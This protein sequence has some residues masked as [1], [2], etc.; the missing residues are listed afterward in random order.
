MYIRYKEIQKFKFSGIYS[1]TNIINGKSYIG[2]SKNIR[3]RIR[4]HLKLLEERKHI[5]KKLSNAVNKYGIDNFK[6]SVLS[7]CPQEYCIKLEQW[8]LDNVKPEYNICKIAG[9]TLG[10]KMKEST[11]KI[12]LKARLGS[13]HSEESRKKMSESR[14]GIINSK[15]SIEKGIITKKKK[16]NGD[17]VS[18]EVRKQMTE[19]SSLSLKGKSFEEKYGKEKS[20][21]I[22]Q[23]MS[24]AKK[25][26]KRNTEDLTNF[27]EARKLR[28]ESTIGKT[29]EEIY[30]SDK[31][32]EIKDKISKSNVSTENKK[33]AG[34]KRR[35]LPQSSDWITKRTSKRKIPLQVTELLT[36]KIHIFDSILETVKY[37]NIS[38]P[39]IINVLKKDGVMKY[40]KLKIEK[41]KF[42]S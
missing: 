18:K 13:K 36:G 28:I 14:K 38:E 19:N 42:L 2:S 34:L 6:F 30:G 12:L 27:L 21:T 17:I 4:T 31:A 9:A 20:N 39:S 1:I 3:D 8:F 11:K 25:E 40:K 16:Y 26:N 7:K 15:E 33:L 29:F 37:F 5:N 23:K 22:K 41:L 35:G 10:I 24:L 32:K